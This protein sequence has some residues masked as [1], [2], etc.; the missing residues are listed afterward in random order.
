VPHPEQNTSSHGVPAISAARI[1]GD[2][3]KSR[4]ADSCPFQR[5][6]TAF[7]SAHAAVS[8]TRRLEAMAMSR[9]RARTSPQYPRPDASFANDQDHFEGTGT[10]TPKEPRLVRVQK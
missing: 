8:A 5:S 9:P 1:V 2:H 7:A 10:L 3:R 4:L 6:M